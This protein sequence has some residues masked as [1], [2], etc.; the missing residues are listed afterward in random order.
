MG[1][2]TV[3][4][5]KNNEGKSNILRALALAMDLMK[6]YAYNPRMLTSTRFLGDMYS[7]ERDYP[8][9]LQ[10]RNPNGYSIVDL[11]FELE[12]I[13]LQRIRELTGIRLNSDLPVR[14]SINGSG[15]KIEIPKRGTPA[16]ANNQNKLKIIEFV[17]NKIDFN[18][19][20]A[21][22]TESNALRVVQTLIEKELYILETSEEYTAAT[23]T[24]ERLQQGVLNDLANKI[25]EP[26]KTFYQLKRFKFVFKKNSDVL[27][28]AGILK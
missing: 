14:V 28:S 16:F 25:V 18:F 24:I 12:E 20:P 10:E 6:R 9:S 5:G 19:M 13:E 4:V 17:C 3:L 7:W 15:A 21:V 2:M 26:L 8:V 23:T 22:R 11:T 27:H 1:N